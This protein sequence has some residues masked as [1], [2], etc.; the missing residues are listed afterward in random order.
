MRVGREA[1]IVPTYYIG[2]Y[3]PCARSGYV[4][5]VYTTPH[6]QPSLIFISSPLPP[7]HSFIYPSPPPCYGSVGQCS[8]CGIVQQ[9][10]AMAWLAQSARSLSSATLYKVSQVSRDL[11]NQNAMR[12]A[13]VNVWHRCSVGVATVWYVQYLCGMC[14]AMRCWRYY[15]NCAVQCLAHIGSRRALAQPCSNSPVC[16]FVQPSDVQVWGSEYNERMS[17]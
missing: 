14:G 2:E 5:Y 4:W 12:L 13:C 15:N 6:S 3:P 16:A 17:V 10:G 1:I 7:L 9:G 11:L 8:M